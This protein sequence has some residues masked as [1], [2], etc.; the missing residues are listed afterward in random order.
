MTFVFLG[1]HHANSSSNVCT[2]TFTKDS[3]SLRVNLVLLVVSENIL[4]DGVGVFD[5]SRSRVF[6]GQSVIGIDDSASGFHGVTVRLG[7]HLM[8]SASDSATT[9]IVDEAGLNGIA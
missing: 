3:Y 4:K 6:G 1:K 8:A 2:T 7:D 5:T 9:M